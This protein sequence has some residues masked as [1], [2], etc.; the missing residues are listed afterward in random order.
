[1]ILE[2]YVVELPRLWED[3]TRE[4]IAIIL[5]NGSQIG[6]FENADPVAGIGNDELY[7]GNRPRT[8]RHWPSFPDQASNRLGGG[9]I[10]A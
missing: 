10:C 6:S 1:M 5:N 7:G 3:A 4:N 2:I 9:S 8:I